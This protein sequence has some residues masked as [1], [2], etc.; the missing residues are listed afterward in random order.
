MV[1]MMNESMVSRYMKSATIEMMNNNGTEIRCLC[2]KCNLGTVFDPYSG[3]VQQH[4]LMCGFMDDYADQDGAAA[5]E[6]VDGQINEGADEEDAGHDDGGEEDAGHDNGGEEVAGYDN[7]GEEEQGPYMLL[8]SVVRDPH[9]Q[10][11]LMKKS[12]N[13]AKEKAKLA[14]LEIDA[15]T[16]LYAGCEPKDTHLKVTL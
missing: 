2:R 8:N 6:N 11:L 16:P 10:E 15:T 13:V 7:G 1:I 12:S 5:L 4:L 9:V 3:L 14:Q